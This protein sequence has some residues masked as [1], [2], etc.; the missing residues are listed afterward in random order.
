MTHCRSPLEKPPMVAL[1]GGAARCSRPVASRITSSWAIPTVA[2]IH[3]RCAAATAGGARLP[4]AA[5]L[6]A[7]SD[8]WDIAIASLPGC[9]RGARL[10][11]NVRLVIKAIPG[12]S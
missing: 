7:A 11:I 5:A 8:V 4:A 9:W 3:P 1:R 6:T 12:T 10:T 2:R